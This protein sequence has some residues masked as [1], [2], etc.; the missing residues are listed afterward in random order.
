MPIITISRGSYSRGK[1]VAEKAAEV[2]GYECISRDIL[3]EASEEFNIPEIKLVRALHDSPSVLERFTHGKE[4]YVSYIRKSL[5]QH[6]QKDNVVY[7]GLAGHYFL[8]DIP[9]VFK[10][11]I[12]ADM[13]DR[14][15]EE[16]RRE[17][18]SKEKALYILKKDDDERRKWGLRVYGIDTWDSRLYDI[19]LK[20]SALTVDDTVDIICHAV[21]K[22]IFKTSPESQKIL[23]DKLL[24][25]K[26][27]AAIVKLLPM[28]KVTSDNGVVYIGST[29]APLNLKNNVLNDIKHTAEKVEGVKEIV[30]CVH[31]TT[32][33]RSVNPFHNI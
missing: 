3:L 15:K 19:V 25:A 26:V 29:D 7:H 14:V 31:E 22:P 28:A 20:V 32:T 16:V 4:R 18:I 27:H 5:L 30:L 11:R 23:N 17:N 24:S 13:D 9:H 10:V 6:V 2:L 21:Q 1:E 12:I 33:S 8:L